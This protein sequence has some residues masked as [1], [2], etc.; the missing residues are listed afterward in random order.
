MGRYF[1]PL[2]ERE[3]ES[4]KGDRK[5]P[6]ESGEEKGRSRVT[7]MLGA[8]VEDEDWAGVE[9]AAPQVLSVADNS[10]L[11]SSGTS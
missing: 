11:R 10:L 3:R 6:A 8:G 9:C 7:H 4:E 2:R 5:G 1:Y